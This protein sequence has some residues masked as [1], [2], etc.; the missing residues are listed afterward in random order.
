MFTFYSRINYF[1]AL[2]RSTSINK[3][4]DC[5]KMDVVILKGLISVVIKIKL[6]PANVSD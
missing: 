2:I 1:T 3:Q 6:P 5:F 4:N